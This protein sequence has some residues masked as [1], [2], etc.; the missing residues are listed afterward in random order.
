MSQHN[1]EPNAVSQSEGNSGQTGDQAPQKTSEEIQDWI[2][3]YI[4]TAMERPADEIDVT[5]PF[6]DFA[7]DSATAIGKACN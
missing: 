3:N 6:D 2:V 4:A 1:T 5:I 7:L